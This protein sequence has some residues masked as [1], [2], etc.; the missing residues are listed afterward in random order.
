MPFCFKLSKEERVAFPKGCFICGCHGTDTFTVRRFSIMPR[1]MIYRFTRL[2]IDVP[3]CSM[4]LR[5]LNYC[6][7]S[8]WFLVALAA[9]LAV[10]GYTKL[11]IVSAF[12]ALSIALIMF[13]LTRRFFIF[14]HDDESITYASHDDDYLI[15][16]C[17]L[18]KTTVF[19]RSYLM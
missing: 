11:A 13:K 19:K 16:L 18:N 7:Y 17:N 3:V 9:V 6:R 5:V 2:S 14:E 8:F 4:H 12:V 15:K 10:V 1:I